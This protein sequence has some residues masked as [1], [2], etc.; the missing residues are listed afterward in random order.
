MMGATFRSGDHHS[1]ATID[2][3]TISTAL[4]TRPT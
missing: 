3:A 1:R 4:G 2:R